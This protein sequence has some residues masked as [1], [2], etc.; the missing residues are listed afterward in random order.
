MSASL[1]RDETSS[2]VTETDANSDTETGAESFHDALE[3]LSLGG[4]EA[5]EHIETPIDNWNNDNSHVTNDGGCEEMQKG[6]FE[7]PKTM[8]DAEEDDS[9]T[10]SDEA[11]EIKEDE[12][13]ILERESQMTVEEKQVFC[14]FICCIKS[15]CL[16][17]K[18]KPILTTNLAACV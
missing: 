9:S 6:D 11:D 3:S 18:V 14:V 15:E 7:S 10:E 12:E 2:S 1:G 4:D 5:L 17:L 16:D 8:E 13:T